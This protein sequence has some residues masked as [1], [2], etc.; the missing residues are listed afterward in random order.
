MIIALLVAALLAL[1]LRG[2][3]VR[4]PSLDQPWLPA[5]VGI[6]WAIVAWYAW[7]SLHPIPLFHD[8]AAYLLQAELFASGRWAAPAP[9]IPEFFTQ[10]HVLVAPV[11]ASKYPPGHSLLLALG[12]LVGLPVLVVVALNAVRIG[13]VFALARRFAGAGVALLT[14]A[15]LAMSPG[16]SRFSA[17]YYSQLT[18]GALLLVAWY[19][20]VRWREQRDVRWL[21]GVAV[22][23]GWCAITRPWSAIAFA[24]PI[25]VVVLRDAWRGRL[26]RQL[27]MAV[28]AGTLVLAILPVWSHQ[29][30]GDWRHTPL[31]LYARDYMPFDFPHFGVVHASPRL[32][33]S[34]DVAAVNASLLKVE[35]AHTW[36]HA[37]RDALERL[38]WY[39]RDLWPASALLLGALF[40]LGLTALPRAAWLAAATLAVQFIAYLAHPTWPQWTVYYF[41][42]TPVALFVAATGASAA[43]QLIAGQRAWR[44]VPAHGVAL[45]AA[46]AAVVLLLPSIALT[47]SGMREALGIAMEPK[48][49]FD[50]Q[51]A[52]LPPQPAIVFV[53][54][55]PRHSPH[56]SFVVNRADWKTAP[57]WVVLDRGLDDARLAAL[58]PDRQPYVYDQE[59]D[60]FVAISAR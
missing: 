38:G 57:V 14:V 31:E 19:A 32:V 47:A 17:S 9:P 20:L 13:L 60:R 3:A 15:F 36:S 50:A 11:L 1:V 8:E 6:A 4:T 35:A 24:I 43:L 25:G 26:W 7:G 5:A 44:T 18:T 10:A 48:A 16:Q 12:E 21:L 2:R 34:P 51:V 28:V 29:T 52:L 40:V 30:T 33:P 22:A 23:I 45:A 53:R 49:R 55:G 42:V 41:E 58:A 46:L 59:H 56:D 37:G 54:Y 27:A 39:A